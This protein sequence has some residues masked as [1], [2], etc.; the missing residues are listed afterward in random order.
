MLWIRIQQLCFITNTE[1]KIEYINPQFTK[2]TGY[3]VEE[4]DG[5][6]PKLFSSGLTPPEVYKELWSTIKSGNTWRGE[7]QN[8]R[9][10]GSLFW[11]SISISN[12]KDEKGDVTHYVAI[13]EDITDRKEA[14]YDLKTSEERFS[15]MVSN[16][17]GI[18]F[19]CKL[20][21][22]WTM[23][24][25]SDKIEEITGYNKDEFISGEKTFNDIIHPD[26]RKFVA[27]DIDRQ[28]SKTPFILIGI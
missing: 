14:E 7:L 5:Q 21:A 19:R 3:S 28:I 4:A 16:I 1:G 17:D 23:L 22:D 24:F 10:D 27:D 15:T 13:E 8:K 2:I 25:L 6:T 9:K 12:V 26:D 18:V 11:A 20:D